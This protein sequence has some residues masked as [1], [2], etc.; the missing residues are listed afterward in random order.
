[1]AADDAYV[2]GK[3]YRYYKCM[4]REPA[5]ARLYG[6]DP[7]PF[8]SLPAEAL[9]GAVWE[10]VGAALLDREQLRT[11][12]AASQAERAAAAE[13]WAT[14]RQTVEQEIA[15][16]RAQLKELL[17]DRTEA[18]R[19]SETR[20]V[21]DEAVSDMEAQ[22]ARLTSELGK[23]TP[24]DLPGITAEAATTIERFA[25]EV[26]AGIGAATPAERREV[27]RLLQVQGTVRRDDERG[28]PFGRY[29]YVVQ[30]EAILTLS[31]NAGRFL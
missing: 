15:R 14:R 9:E 18:P 10:R 27:L 25:D 19:G 26:R 23:L 7:C 2:G 5:R 13:Q 16:R 4:R 6:I 12:L 30:L 3:H 22:L 8:P 1:L 28:V 29:A 17:I 31:D 20:R 21:L 24:V 11:G